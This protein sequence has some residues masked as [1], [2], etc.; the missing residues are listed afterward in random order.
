MKYKN[1]K[2]HILAS[3][4]ETLL[5]E[6][7]NTGMENAVL[8]TIVLN[9]HLHF[10]HLLLYFS[11]FPNSQYSFAFWW[12]ISQPFIFSGLFWFRFVSLLVEP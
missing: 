11:I 5:K 10:S 12:R 4:S 8:N 6:I 1:V 3:E 9:L 2:V 7:I